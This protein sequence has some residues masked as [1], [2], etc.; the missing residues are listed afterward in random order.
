MY[1]NLLF[2]S[3]RDDHNKNRVKAFIKRMLQVSGLHQP[4]FV[5]GVL[6]TIHQLRLQAADV[7]S[8]LAQPEWRE[9]EGEECFKDVPDSVPGSEDVRE[10]S[11]QARPLQRESQQ[12]G[13]PT[14][15]GRKRDPEYSSAERSC[16]WELVGYI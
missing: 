16:L 1:L 15:N 3:L 13:I 4:P 12:T 11:P 10:A 6:Y 8:M 5:C 14:Y 7:D 2:K 9:A